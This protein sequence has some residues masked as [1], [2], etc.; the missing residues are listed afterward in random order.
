M[1]S[2]LTVFIASAVLFAA[3]LII[4]HIEERRGRRIFLRGSRGYADRVLLYVYKK[5]GAAWDDFVEY[6]VKLGWYYSIHSFLLAFMNVLVSVY[7]YLET[8]FEDNR[9]RAT[10]IHSKKRERPG[11]TQL[12]QVAEHKDHVAL[13]PDEKERL[14]SEKLEERD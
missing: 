2:A 14:K 8:K 1:L 9:A 10:V 3:L 13:T 6:V 5:V 7:D 12:D 4:I 11:Q